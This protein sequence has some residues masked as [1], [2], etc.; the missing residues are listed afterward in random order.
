MA[1]SSSPCSLLVPQSQSLGRSLPVAQRLF[2]VLLIRFEMGL[3]G[4]TFATRSDLLRRSSWRLAN[5]DGG[6]HRST[7]GGQLQA[8]EALAS[9]GVE[10]QSVT[11]VTRDGFATCALSGAAFPEAPRTGA[12]VCC[13]LGQLYLRD[14]V[15]EFLTKT[16]MFVPGM[17]DT[18]GLEEAHG[19]I[20]RLRDVFDVVLTPNRAR[21]E[22]NRGGAGVHAG[23]W[24][25]P[26]DRDVSTNGQ[27]SFVALRPC[28][29]VMRERVAT[30]LART[31]QPAA[32]SSTSSLRDGVSTIQGGA[33][34]CPVCAD[35]VEVS[36]RLFPEADVVSRLRLAFKGERER[37]RQRKAGK[38]KSR[39]ESMDGQ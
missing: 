2:A 10:H 32:S 20:E 30:E 15:V 24:T 8:D 23:L 16:G 7:R 13:S 25:C 4:G 6:A 9:Y 19:H 22:D 28:G 17:C 31:K 27:H 36:V 14:A 21:A 11:A 37:K 26:I 5:T 33:W 35:A 18:R 38:R 34:S 1:R 12:I 39:D 3:D 29:H